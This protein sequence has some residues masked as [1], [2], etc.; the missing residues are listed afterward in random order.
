MLNKCKPL[1]FMLVIIFLQSAVYVT[2]F[3]DIQIARQVIG[4]VYLTLVPGI[5]FLK[6]LKFDGLDKLEIVLLSIGFSLAFLMLA[7]LLLN[8][9]GLLLGISSPLSL[10]PLM[11][12]LNGC[13]LVGGILAYLREKNAKHLEISIPRLHPSVLV[14]LVIPILSIAGA[15]WVNV[16]ENNLILL[17]MI[18]AIS[19]LF[20]VG[21]ISKK[22][23]PPNLYPLALLMIAIAL[24]F[25]SSLISN[26]ILP[27]GSDVPAEYFV[28]KTTANSGHWIATNPYL[29]D[30]GYGR[31]NAMLS[32]TILPTIYANVLNI[33]PT[34]VFKAL[35]P[36]LFSLVPLGLYQVWQAYFGRKYAFIAAFLFVA[37]STFFTEMLGLNRQMVAELFFVLLLLVLLKKRMTPLNKTTCFVIFSVALVTSHYALAEIFLCFIF[38]A[39]ISLIL[40]KRPSRN[41]RA[42]MAVFFFVIM[43]SWYI[44]TSGSAVF[45]SFLSFGSYVYGQLGEFFNPA[46]RGQAVLLG[47]GAEAAPS[48]LNAISR[49]FAYSTEA[50]IVIGF[51]A[52]VAKRARVRVERDYF[53][54]CLMAIAFLALLILVPG[55]ANTMNMSRFYHILLFFLAPLCVVGG[56][57]LVRLV[58]KSREKLL[59]SVLMLAVLVPYFLFQTG[60][61]YEV[62]GSDS[63]SAPLSSYRMDPLRLYGQFGYIDSLSVAGAQWLSRQINAGNSSLYADTSMTY[64]V[65]TI[66]GMIYGGYINGLSNITIVANGGTVF[67]SRL[68]VVYDTIADG[69]IS[70]NS[71]DLSYLKDMSQIYNNGEAVILREN[72]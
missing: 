6:L 63:W 21:V 30:V 49:A 69:G 5:I 17:Y 42:S 45:N 23:L 55:L 35:F 72:R 34:W 48:I 26:Y 14:L 60:F 36:L 58:S 51:L 28:F 70:W 32:V 52:L 15:M 59:V 57:F 37:Q 66:Y 67:L 39:L 7:G 29:G 62:A 25:H 46:S 61:V 4:F 33:D 38:F 18:I 54:F 22:L 12:V 40:M 68:N 1:D 3:F 19:L 8:E 56:Q 64:S 41:I 65:L 53:M 9:F 44:Y 43:F 24:I 50:L 31:L 27:F 47:L 2:T 10:T 71:S 16:F 11:L 20:A 13:I